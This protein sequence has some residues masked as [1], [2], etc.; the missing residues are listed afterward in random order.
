MIL[1][2]F[3]FI[4]RQYNT[5]PLIG[6]GLMIY[7]AAMAFYGIFGQAIGLSTWYTVKGHEIVGALTFW[8]LLALAILLG[9][10]LCLFSWKIVIPSQAESGSEQGWKHRNPGRPYIERIEKID[11]RTENIEKLLAG[12]INKPK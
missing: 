5:G 4:F 3:K 7:G 11:K 10:F 1:K 2:I 9:L 12:L 6:R 8:G